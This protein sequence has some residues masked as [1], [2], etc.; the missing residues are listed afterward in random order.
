MKNLPRE[1]K[2]ERF[3][4]GH[5]LMGVAALIVTGAVGLILA[6]L[7]W[8]VFAI[9]VLGVT[10]FIEATIIHERGHCKAVNAKT[11]FQG[12]M[13]FYPDPQARVENPTVAN[14]ILAIRPCTYSVNQNKRVYVSDMEPDALY[15][16]ALSGPLANRNHAVF[17]GVVSAATG[18]LYLI[19]MYVRG[20]YTPILLKATATALAIAAAAA[21]MNMLSWVCN[22]LAYSR[23]DGMLMRMAQ[24]AKGFPT[25]KDWEYTRCPEEKERSIHWYL[26]YRLDSVDTR[27]LRTA[28]PNFADKYVY[29]SPGGFR[30]DLSVQV[31]VVDVNFGIAKDAL[32]RSIIQSNGLVP[33]TASAWAALAGDLYPK[34]YGSD[35]T[36]CF[37]TSEG[38][39]MR[40][41]N[42]ERNGSGYL[43]TFYNLTEDEGQKSFASL[44]EALVFLFRHGYRLP[45]PPGHYRRVKLFRRRHSL[46]WYQRIALWF[47]Y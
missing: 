45:F 15:W 43:A 24:A 37:S 14:R 21:A 32:D 20:P 40:C 35:R 18:S 1:L 7:K 30:N 38:P 39:D 22:L 9:I 27:G 19:F 26:N 47:R 5:A 44:N 11:P 3:T 41:V 34:E 2:P 17:W 25:L 6:E 46:P 29:Y 42:L 4:F 8:S 23:T 33:F 12:K 28:V 16:I 13:G 10:A 36:W 31:A